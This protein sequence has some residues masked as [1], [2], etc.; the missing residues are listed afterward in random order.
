MVQ[1]TKKNTTNRETGNTGYTGRRK[2]KQNTT[3]YALDTTLCNKE[4]RLIRPQSS[5]KQLEV[6]MNRT[7]VYVEIVT[8]FTTRNS[9]LFVIYKA[10]FRNTICFH[11]ASNISIVDMS[12]LMPYSRAC[13]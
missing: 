12:K 5:Y 10:Y 6:K 9:G 13:C 11:R 2:I 3:Q 1:K 4:I 8:D 7:S